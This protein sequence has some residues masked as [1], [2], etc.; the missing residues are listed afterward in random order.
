MSFVKICHISDLHC[1]DSQDW[2]DNFKNLHRT[3]VK[4]LPDI[5]CITGDCVNH[6][7]Q[8]SFDI[9]ASK[10]EELVEAY[11]NVSHNVY[12][13]TVPGNHDYHLFGNS[14]SALFK[15]Q[16][17]NLF[18]KNHKKLLYCSEVRSADI[19]EVALNIYEKFNIAI[20]P[21]DSNQI[22]KYTTGNFAQG[23]IHD[24]EKDYEA[25]KKH[26]L[27]ESDEAAYDSSFKVSLLHHHPLPLPTSK[28][29]EKLEGFMV[30]KNSYEFLDHSI[31][32]DVDLILHGHKHCSGVSE[33]KM[34]NRGSR[35]INVVACG[36][37]AHTGE[38]YKE[39]KLI[40]LSDKHTVDLR[41][42]YATNSTPAYIT[43]DVKPMELVSYGAIRKAN[44]IA[45][46]L[47]NSPIKF[48]SQK[49]KLVSIQ[50]DG[51]AAVGI[52]YNGIFWNE[53]IRYDDM[54]ISETLRADIGRVLSLSSVICEESQ[55]ADDKS[56]TWTSTANVKANIDGAPDKPEAF[57]FIARPTR[58]LNKE[59]E[60]KSTIRYIL[61]NG[62][63]LT[64]TDYK[65]AY[66]ENASGIIDETCSIQ[67]NYPTEVL[68]LVVKFPSGDPSLFPSLSQVYVDATERPSE[69][70]ETSL[71][72]LER[73]LER[74]E[75]EYAFLESK[76]AIRYRQD[77]LEIVAVIRHPQPDLL[78]TLRW[79]LPD[80]KNLAKLNH[81]HYKVSE[82][83][84]KKFL[85]KDSSALKTFYDNVSANIKSLTERWEDLDILL[86]G[87]DSKS[88]CL[89]VT[90][91]PD[92][93]EYAKPIFVGRGVVGKS[94][95]A[96]QTFYWNRKLDNEE[97]EPSD[98]EP[99]SVI[100]NYDPVEVLALPLAYPRISPSEYEKLS[101]EG[102][103]GR[104]PVFG[105]ISMVSTNSKLVLDVFDGKVGDESVKVSILEV[106][107]G[108]IWDELTSNFKDL[109]LN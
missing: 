23:K 49:T 67:A 58:P 101:S 62:Y 43:D 13:I 48:I 12:I 30:L 27:S 11:K 3:L 97:T 109:Q 21:F 59:S 74:D 91:G 88:K 9:L 79:G 102:D 87:H 7:I 105:V 104:C 28:K 8:K 40:R 36:S 45:P 52:V 55:L 68:E 42:F 37:S 14:V 38:S 47:I 100:D 65:E 92:K 53:N 84:R 24:P 54:C 15:T 64:R 31:R 66:G 2:D 69:E 26:Y 39:M 29:A 35:S 71:D 56:L 78:Y 10:I 4:E 6:P 72:I 73:K 108:F 99:E 63:A 89:Q 34:H 25:Y 98:A 82:A 75:Q 1:Q 32:N 81:F 44:A 51:N 50:K 107:Y 61:V 18:K 106:L 83:L 90:L 46:C 16:V 33:Y 86:L 60:A 19:M 85:N 95:R 80:D 94:F 5:I 20:F 77:A 57:E 76:H 17:N 22:G 103:T 96:R 93:F 41:T 70:Q